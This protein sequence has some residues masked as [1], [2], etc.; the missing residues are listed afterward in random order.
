MIAALNALSHWARAAG[1]SRAGLVAIILAEALGAFISVAAF[2][3][4]GQAATPT[5]FDVARRTAS[6]VS[7]L[8]YNIQGAA[9]PN[10]GSDNALTPVFNRLA[11][12]ERPDAI[13][14]QEVCATQSSAAW[15]TLYTVYGYWVIWR[16][17][18]AQAN[19]PTDQRIGDLVAVKNSL[20]PTAFVNFAY[21]SQ[22]AGSA[23]FNPQQT[24]LICATFTK[25]GHDIRVCSTHLPTSSTV[26]MS[27]I[28]DSDVSE[29]RNK[30]INWMS[31]GMGVVIAGDFND[32]P[33]K[34]RMYKMY[35]INLPDT[36]SI[37][38]LNEACQLKTGF[39]PA[40]RGEGTSTGDEKIDYVFFS[41]N[42]SA[43]SSGL[44]CDVISSNV[45][46]IF[47]S[48]H[49]MLRGTA[50]MVWTPYAP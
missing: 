33:N 47:Y 42:M 32:N 18:N 39:A 17:I 11:A 1:P 46:G 25:G 7:V 8:D 15:N 9:S 2:P 29:I 28:R 43:M 5:L 19:C 14:L 50:T 31:Q 6:E 3:Q 12:G 4:A 40:R 21:A 48:D 45:G 30:V 35:N 36:E 24:G 22:P 41:S 38:R 26:D 27:G 49:S 34:A 10:F 13:T 20:A 37:G 23:P 44:S 16:P